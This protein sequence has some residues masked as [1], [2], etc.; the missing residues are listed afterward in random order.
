MGNREIKTSNKTKEEIEEGF[1]LRVTTP[2]RAC[3]PVLEVGTHL[4]DSRAQSGSVSNS[5]PVILPTANY[6]VFSKSKH[7]DFNVVVFF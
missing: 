2:S 6:H 7:L 4:A 1:Y 5:W 3:E